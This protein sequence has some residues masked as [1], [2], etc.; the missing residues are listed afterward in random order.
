M[1]GIVGYLKLT[2]ESADWSHQLPEATNAIASRGPDAQAYANMGNAGLGHVRLSI[3]DVS[4]AGNQPMYAHNGRYT[5]V[6]NGEIFNFKKHREELIAAGVQL[7]SDTDTEVLLHMYINEGPSFLNKLN[8]F[9]PLPFTTR[10]KT[11]FLLLVIESELN[12]FIIT[13]MIPTLPLAVN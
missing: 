11:N 6:Y 10:I 12:H 13:K 3:L 8:G 7:T 9:S 4:E 2:P 5:I 1:C